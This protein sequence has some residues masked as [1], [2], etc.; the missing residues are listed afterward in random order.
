MMKYK[1]VYLIGIGGIGMSALARYFKATGSSVSGSDLEDSKILKELRREGIKVKIGHKK[2]NLPRKLDLVVYNQAILADNV[3]IKEAKRRGIVPISYPEV[4]GELTKQYKTVAIAGSHGKST[5]TALMSMILINA[6]LDPIVIIGTRVKEFGNTNFRSGSILGSRTSLGKSDFL[7]L[8]A[9]E[10]GRAFHHYS[11]FA[12]LITNIDKEHLDTYINLAGV[13][14]SFLK[15]ISNIQN[16]GILVLNSADK[17]TKSLE[18]KIIKICKPKKV[19]IYWYDVNEHLKGLSSLQLLP[20]LLGEHNISN[21]SGSF[22]LAKAIKIQ[23]Q[24]IYATLKNF[25]GTWRRLEF[26]SNL[27]LT[28]NN[29][30]LKLSK[31]SELSAKSYKLAVYDDYAHH[32][33]EIKASLAALKNNNNKHSNILENVG[34]LLPEIAKQ[35]NNLICVFQPH[36]VER[37]TILFND[38]VDAFRDADFLILL[39]IYKV[40]GREKKLGLRPKLKLK[41]IKNIESRMNSQFLAKAIQKKYPDKKVIYLKNPNNIAKIISDMLKNYKLTATSYT[42]V[43]MGAGDII[44]YTDLL[45]QDN[46]N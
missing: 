40:P 18:N 11:P 2:A 44:K 16:D 22:V 26:R 25:K 33:T 7:V 24:I 10:Y 39:P 5:T 36:Q 38:F 19:S 43:L 45:L 31:T 37:L 17:N 35:N 13:K 15:F 3:E 42:L 28:T 32:P 27:Q 12:A 1:Q 21:A 29:I 34:M 41:E 4:I 46:T 20:S 9:D 8:E 14:K 6:G 30:Q 23:D